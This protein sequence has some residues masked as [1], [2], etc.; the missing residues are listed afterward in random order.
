VLNTISHFGHQ[1]TEDDG[2]ALHNLLVNFMLEAA[3]LHEGK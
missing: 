2:E 3:R 1:S